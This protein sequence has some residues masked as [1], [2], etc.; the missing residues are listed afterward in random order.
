VGGEADECSN[1]NKEWKCLFSRA[2][3]L[4]GGGGG[5]K[6]IFCEGS[7]G[8]VFYSAKGR[9]EGK[10]NRDHKVGEKAR[11]RSMEAERR[12]LSVGK[13]ISHQPGMPYRVGGKTEL[14]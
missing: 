9:R 14:G 5:G 13:R 10:R 4:V 7:R 11:D 8:G 12:A 3:K 6:G 1:R 2:G